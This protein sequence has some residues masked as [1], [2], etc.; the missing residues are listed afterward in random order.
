M[1]VLTGRPGSGK[2]RYVLDKVRAWLRERAEFRLIVPTNTM[3]EHLRNQL[4]REGFVFRPA[5][6]VTFSKF[7]ESLIPDLP[8]V[9]TAALELLVEDTLARIPLQEFEKVRTFPGFR[10]AVVGQI[11]ELAAAGYGSRDLRR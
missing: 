4:V 3:A 6:I 7:I 9:S 2:T 8:P 11:Q 10:E 5:A 1:Q